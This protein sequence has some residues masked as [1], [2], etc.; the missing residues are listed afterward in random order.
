MGVHLSF[1]TSVAHLRL[2]NNYFGCPEEIAVLSVSPRLFVHEGVD[3]NSTI[4]F[5]F[6]EPLASTP[7]DRYACAV[8]YEKLG[9]AAEIYPFDEESQSC[10]VRV[11]DGYGSL[12]RIAVVL[13]QGEQAILEINGTHPEY[14]FFVFEPLSV[15]SL[16]EN[17][18]LLPHGLSN[19]IPYKL[20]L[21]TAAKEALARLAGRQ[22]VRLL[23]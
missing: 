13:K 16:R 11:Q 18:R 15:A 3:F 17:V 21:P 20:L 10:P 22:D 8:T 7:K 6:V 23:A 5:Q 14:P 2:T 19:T 12:S 9:S 1:G 4:T